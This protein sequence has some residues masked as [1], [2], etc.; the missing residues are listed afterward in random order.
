MVD[1]VDVRYFRR[2]GAYRWSPVVPQAYA[3]ARRSTT[4]VVHVFGLRDGLTTPVAMGRLAARRPYLVEPMGML[5]PRVRSIGLKNAFDRTV[6]HRL[7]RR[8]AALI[9]T[10]NQERHEIA[11][12]VPGATVHLRRN[13]IA[14]PGPVTADGA[15]RRRLGVGENDLLVAYVGRVST[16]KGLDLLAEAIAKT[17]GVHAL[18]VGP[19]AGDGGARQLQTAIAR[20]R[21]SDR[22]HVEPARWGIARDELVAACDTFVLPSRTENFGNAAAEAAA[23][24]IA[25]VVTDQCGIAE[26]VT[27]HDAGIVCA[28]STPALATALATLR[29]DEQRRRRCGANA[30]EL[31]RELEPARI[32]ALQDDIYNGIL[33]CASSS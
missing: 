4:D 23:L 28:V 3:A 17:P 11:A 30:R 8:A 26:L 12:A 6:A 5:V 21:V 33:E 2:A 31:A 29:D 16:K 20:A 14:A 9:A 18:I 19:D 13:P 27:P 25:L 32:A 24:G 22:V 15:L 1:G 7:L 10:S